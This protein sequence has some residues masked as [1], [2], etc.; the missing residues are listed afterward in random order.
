MS[1][2]FARLKRDPRFRRPKKHANKVE[3]DPRFKSL[4]E[5]KPGKGAGGPFVSG[6]NANVDIEQPKSINTVVR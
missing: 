6:M 2:R 4:L 5:E 3:I 1:E